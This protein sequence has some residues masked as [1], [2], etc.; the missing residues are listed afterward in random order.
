MV[1]P[2]RIER[3][4]RG[5]GKR[6]D[7]IT[8]RHEKILEATGSQEYHAIT[9]TARHGTAQ[10]D[11][12]ATVTRTGNGSPNRDRNRKVFPSVPHED[13]LPSSRQAGWPH[14]ASTA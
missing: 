5:L 2:T 12:R 8:P 11:T 14:G 13:P 4:T 3:A 1:P 6:C 7:S 10:R 9:E